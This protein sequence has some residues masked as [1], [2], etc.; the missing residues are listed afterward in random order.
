M[1]TQRPTVAR[2]LTHF[3]QDAETAQV[4]ADELRRSSYLGLHDVRCTYR[5]GVLTLHGRL[6]SFY[7]KQV[8]QSLVRDLPNVRR[9]ENEIE[10]ARQPGHALLAR[11]PQ[12]NRAAS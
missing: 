1:I 4:A 8:A 9:I 12:S 3:K 5:D 11:D 10:V 7:L 6:Y 2:T